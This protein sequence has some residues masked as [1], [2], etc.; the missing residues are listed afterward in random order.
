MAILSF[1]RKVNILYIW[2]RSVIRSRV[3]S[4][5]GEIV[6]V[7]ELFT[8]NCH[9]YFY[10]LACVCVL[11]VWRNK[12]V[13]SYNVIKCSSNENRLFSSKKKNN[14][15]LTD[16]IS[17]PFYFLWP[18][19]SFIGLVIAT[20]LLIRVMSWSDADKKSKL[21]HERTFQSVFKPS[22]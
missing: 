13:L 20:D 17:I 5:I 12:N 19:L 22:V 11:L 10:R 14:R 18:R 6:Q 21:S 15:S 8:E 1:G 3:A 9:M 16:S 2:H 4:P 7:V